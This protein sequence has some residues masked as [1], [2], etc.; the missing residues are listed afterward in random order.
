[1]TNNSPADPYSSSA[2]LSD[3][4][5]NLAWK[6]GR[7]LSASGPMETSDAVVKLRGQFAAVDYQL[8]PVADVAGMEV[9]VVAVEISNTV[10]VV[11]DGAEVIKGQG[12]SATSYTFT[13]GFETVRLWCDGAQWY[14]LGVNG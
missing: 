3:S 4:R 1:M 13:V 12:L 9:T 8:L 14:V 2:T 7:L 11:A 10:R 5:A 6:G